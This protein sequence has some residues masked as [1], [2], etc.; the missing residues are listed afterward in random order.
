MYKW[1]ITF[2]LDNKYLDYIHVLSANYAKDIAK[3][4]RIPIEKFI[5]IPFGIQDK[6]EQWKD[7]KCEYSNYSLAIG[8]SNRD[9]DFLIDLWK[10]IPANEKLV[11][12]CDEY[13]PKDKLP[14]N[15]ILR[16]DII[17]DLQ[18]PYLKNAKLIIIPIKD[19]N[20]CSGDTVLLESMSLG[21]PI[22]IT[23]PSTL[24]EMYL[25][26][27][28]NGIGIPKLKYEAKD[29]LINLLNDK[30]KLEE[31]SSNSRSC[32]EKNYS[33]YIMGKNLGSII[34]ARR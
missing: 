29:I 6:S 12:I 7:A 32:F 28:E 18:F 19:E 15:V 21:K 9:Y 1:V 16:K 10:E 34:K 30:E 13:K 3:Q 24:G 11:I 23:V 31:L 17:G 4:F 26:E 2:I 8:R 22:T 33:R 25:R 27:G 20:I 14:E 5:V